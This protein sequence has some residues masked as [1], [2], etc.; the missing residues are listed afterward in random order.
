M[1]DAKFEIKAGSISFTG[2]GTEA[3][4]A[5]QLDKVL[6]KLTDLRALGGATGRHS[7]TDNET[8]RGDENPAA[9][10][11]VGTLAAYLKEA[12]PAI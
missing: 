7:G 4:L 12:L 5:E 9:E 1:A 2:E 11:S 8:P 10:V 3:W 6:S